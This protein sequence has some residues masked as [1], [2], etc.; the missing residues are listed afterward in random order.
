VVVN[1]KSVKE[2]RVKKIYL[3]ERKS[4]TKNSFFSVDLLL[5]VSK[6]AKKPFGP[7]EGF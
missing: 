6:R 7:R 4:K 1:F 5:G 2:N 3:K